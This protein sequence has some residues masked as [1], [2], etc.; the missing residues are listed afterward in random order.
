VLLQFLRE[1][2]INANVEAGYIAW[3]FGV[4][5]QL[6]QSADMINRSISRDFVPRGA[7]IVDAE[8]GQSF[9]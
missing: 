4:M 9:N 1:H 7:G 6:M 3:K 2:G 8:T 5:I